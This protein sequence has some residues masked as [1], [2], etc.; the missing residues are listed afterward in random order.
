MSATIGLLAPIDDDR[1]LNLLYTY[2]SAIENA[3]GVPIIL[4]YT[5]SE[6]T[7]RR[8]AEL[9]DGFCFTG[10]VDIE[11]RRFAEET[12]N[13]CGKIQL[14]RDKLELSMFDIVFKEKKPIMGIC[15]GAQVINVALGGTLYQ[16]IP[17]EIQTDIQH[18]QSEAKDMHSHEIIIYTG[19][20]YYELIGKER[21][22]ANSFHHQSVKVLGEGLKVMAVADDGVIEALYYE[23]DRYIRAYQW[24]PERLCHKDENHK[25]IFT[26]FI[27]AVKESK[28]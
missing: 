6:E 18:R 1:Q 4:P 3:G 17:T 2:V 10:G 5:E 20:P 23:G 24:H 26:D 7:M 14:Y 22:P 16:D 28:K 21:I 19:T 11:P 25:C 9:C 15:R 12:K 8:Y 27:N 13:S